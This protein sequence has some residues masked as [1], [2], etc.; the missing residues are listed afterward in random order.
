[1]PHAPENLAVLEVTFNSVKLAWNSTGNTTSAPV[2]SYLVQYRPNC[3]SVDYV[4]ISVLKP[5]VSVGGLSADTAYE[6]H[7]HAVNDAGRS[8]SSASVV[9]TTSHAG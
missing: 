8:L 3:S 5:E 2:L 6:F 4:E 1:M 9:V 7:V